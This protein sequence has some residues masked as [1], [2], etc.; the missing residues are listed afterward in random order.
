MK[1]FLLRLPLLLLICGVTGC[2]QPNLRFAPTPGA[3]KTMHVK[4]TAILGGNGQNT[5]FSLETQLDATP[6]TALGDTVV[7]LF[8]RF[9]K[10]SYFA[11][12]PGQPKIVFDSGNPNDTT[13]LAGL[14]NLIGK[15]FELWLRRNGTVA[16]AHPPVDSLAG[17]D[18]LA[19]EMVDGLRAI[20]AVLPNKVVKQNDTWNSIETTSSQALDLTV[21]L[22]WHCDNIQDGK[23][24]L[25]FQGVCDAP[26]ASGA[27][28][29][30]SGIDVQARGGRRGTATVDLATGN[31]LQMDFTDDFTVS[32]IS[33]PNVIQYTLG[34]KLTA[35]Q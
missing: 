24:L 6:Q 22:T 25:S 21:R 1:I 31:T 3:A 27:Y 17:F 28:A 26:H 34:R 9:D 20:N 30:G 23:A 4:C 19:V 16:K 11:E 5:I 8:Y 7:P 32:L 33:G 10:L 18:L 14:K 2:S 29:A 12:T 15:S 35:E 13:R